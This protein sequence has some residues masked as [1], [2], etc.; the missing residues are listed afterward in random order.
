MCAQIPR[1]AAMD[2]IV[3]FP[4]LS[5]LLTCAIRASVNMRVCVLALLEITQSVKQT[6]HI[7]RKL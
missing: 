7:I 5:I 3:A 4:Y 1:R 2:E 6:V